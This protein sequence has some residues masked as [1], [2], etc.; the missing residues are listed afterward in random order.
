MYGN[1]INIVII[2]TSEI[3][4]TGL[5]EIVAG[6]CENNILKVKSIT[7]IPAYPN[8]MGCH[9]IILTPIYF[10]QNKALFERIFDNPQA[11]RYLFLENS[12]HENNLHV[13]DFDDS[14]TSICL[15]VSDMLSYFL[16]KEQEASQHTLS[17]R[18]TDV[19]KLI[20]KG[21]KNKEIAEKLF[22][23]PHTVVTHRKN[24]TEKLNIKS[25]SGLTV[26]AVMKK[27]INID[28]I[29]PDELI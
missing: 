11:V 8:I 12:A 7:E 6:C 2:H 4:L 15:K 3:V 9:L 18:E 22:I 16:I 20:V 1:N 29:N 28:E 10:S 21:L 23:S 27:I 13:L 14:A 25:T 24:I 5:S 17:E 26:Y 19:L